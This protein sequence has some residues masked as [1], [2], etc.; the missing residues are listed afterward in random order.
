MSDLRVAIFDVDGTLVDSQND[1]V[2]SMTRAFAA[3]DR[4]APPREA[5]VGIVGLSLE[6]AV[7]RLDPALDAPT[8]TAAVDAYKDAY[9]AMR[10]AAGAAK[11]SPLYPGA[12]DVLD[13]LS[14]RDDLLL[15]VA[16]GKSRRGLSALLDNHG[17]GRHF[18]SEQVSDHHPSKPHPAMIE[19]VLSETG[20]D[21]ARAVMIG[22]TS[23]DIDMGRSAG[24]RTLAVAW[25]YHRAEDLGADAIARDFGQIPALI[26]ELLA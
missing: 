9:A 4:P 21:R 2:A 26:E 20:V 23:F 1:I 15:A 22:D 19:A 13:E 6:H 10:A 3:I 18:V 17:L 16:T 11:S 12:R 25:G 14:D 8:V 24:V 7:H 5:V